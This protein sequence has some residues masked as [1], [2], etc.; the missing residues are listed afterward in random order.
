MPTT[1]RN[2]LICVLA[3]CAC[4]FAQTTGAQAPE[5]EP[6]PI[7]VES[8]EVLVPVLV[9][10]KKRLDA[11]HQT[12]IVDFLKQA[13]APNSHF[14]DD[15]AV[16][17]LSA[18]SFHIFEDGKEQ[19]IQGVTTEAGA[20]LKLTWIT[21]GSKPVVSNGAGDTVTF[22]WPGYLVAYMPPPSPEGS[23]H[24]IV[25]KVDR[26]DSAVYARPEYCNVTHAVNDPLNGTQFGNQLEADLNSSKNGNLKLSLEVFSAFGT[27]RA[28][29]LTDVIVE[30]AAKRRWLSDCSKKPKIG[31]LGL[32]YTSD[33]RITARFSG[34][35][36]GDLGSAAQPIPNR[37]GDDKSCVLSGPD[38]YGTNLDLAPGQYLLRVVLR[39]GKKFGR[40]EMPLNLSSYAGQNLEISEVVLAKRYRQVTEGS[41]GDA[42]TPTGQ[43]LPL[44]VRGF[45][46]LPAMENRFKKGDSLD[47]YLE[48]YASQQMA[49][50]S[51]TIE[52]NLRVVDVKKGQVVKTLQPVDATHYAKAGDPVI[53]IGG[54]IDVSALPPGSY[55]LEAQATDSAGDSTPW[56]TANFTIEP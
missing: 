2:A 11:S 45:E 48:V 19:N 40:T 30:S 3:V 17:G 53:P 24:Q 56:R 51:S 12:D 49:A 1:G 50:P 31:V 18:D 26:A 35:Q 9:L 22:H 20:P 14:L 43:Y 28:G 27:V 25:V 23:C 15:I 42:A 39:D 32:V 52:A 44:V 13:S 7:H 36:F 16:T 29:Y 34:L 33:G 6:Q 4:I 41:S 54:G 37:P 10:D 55:R 38:Q 47:F 21:T 5:I 46:V 8:N